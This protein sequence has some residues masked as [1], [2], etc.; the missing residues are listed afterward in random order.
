[1]LFFQLFIFNIIV[2]SVIAWAALFQ[3]GRYF[4]PIVIGLI[5]RLLLIF[6]HE[7]TRVF[8]EMDLSDYESDFLLF[9]EYH[10]L[11]KPY[12]GVHVPAYVVLYPGWLYYFFGHDGIWLIRVANAAVSLFVMVPLI[13]IHRMILGKKLS[14]N[15]ALLVMLWPSWLRYSIE[16]GRS[17]AGAFF[18]LF[19]L[20]YL[21]EFVEN[22]SLKPFVVSVV[23]S[24][25]AIF[26][27][28]HHVAYFV[29]MGVYYLIQRLKNIRSKYLKFIV[30]PVVVAF[31]LL[32]LSGS[33]RLYQ[34][35]VGGGR[36]DIQSVKQLVMFTQ[37]RETG[38]SAYLRGVYPLSMKDFIW[39]LPLQAFYFMFS[40]MPWDAAKPFVIGSSI[41]AWIILIIV[42]RSIRYNWQFYRRNRSLKILM[43][44]FLFVI[45]GWGAVSKNAG[46]VE[47]QRMPITLALL[48]IVPV[49]ARRPEEEEPNTLEPILQ[50]N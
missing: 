11:G 7:Y 13:Q 24:I 26:L 9:V 1:M 12:W 32:A 45:V 6:V 28:V 18:V 5:A 41:Q 8:G 22:S 36:F 29:P 30:F 44:C 16:V 20:R 25:Y 49:L 46:A 40:P 23:V 27:R 37:I 10:K 43:L 15:I 48:S 31:V 3:R 34:G 50:A 2:L 47:R 35:F 14:I 38:G 33:V 4:V 42:W 19:A 39:Y 17:A 21:L